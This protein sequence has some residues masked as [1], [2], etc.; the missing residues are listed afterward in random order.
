MA[1][2]IADDD[3]EIMK[4]GEYPLLGESGISLLSV[5]KP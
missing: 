4:K 3:E 2:K 1:G 5:S